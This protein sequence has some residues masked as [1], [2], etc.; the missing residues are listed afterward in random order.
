MHEPNASP[1]EL[2][3]QLRRRVNQQ[4]S[5][6]RGDEGGAAVTLI[7]RVGGVADGAIAAEHGNAHRRTCS[8]KGE[9]SVCWHLVPCGGIVNFPP[10]SWRNGLDGEESGLHCAAEGQPDAIR[11]P[12]PASLGEHPARRLQA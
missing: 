11:F 4:V 7:S 8:E 3:P 1:Q 5:V 2:E 9:G 6:R 10:S 12:L